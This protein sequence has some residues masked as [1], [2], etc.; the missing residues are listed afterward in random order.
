MV[1][2]G[3][4]DEEGQE[5]LALSDLGVDENGQPVM[6]ADGAA[7]LGMPETE[8]DEF[9]HNEELLNLR[10]KRSLRLKQNIGDF[11]DQNPQIAAKLVQTWLRGEEE[12]DARSSTRKRAKQ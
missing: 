10:M 12:N 2:E 7:A 8:E 3:D 9:A 4:L 11:V 1:L 5:S 6:T